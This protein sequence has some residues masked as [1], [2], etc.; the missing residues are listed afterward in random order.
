MVEVRGDLRALLGNMNKATTALRSTLGQIEGLVAENREP[1]RDFTGSGLYE[2]S[3]L[4][5]ELRALIKQFNRVTT[6]VERDP[7]RFFFG[8]SQQ[9]Y[10]AGQ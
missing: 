5:I 3:S 4:L 1:I 2:V 10:E 8:D 9:G 7:A 6:E